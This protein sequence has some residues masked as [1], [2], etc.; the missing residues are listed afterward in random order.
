MSDSW[1]RECGLT[2]NS[3]HTAGPEVQVA[4]VCVCALCSVRQP[5]PALCH[6]KATGTRVP[7]KLFNLQ[8]VLSRSLCGPK[9]P[10]RAWCGPY[11]VECFSKG[12]DS[13]RAA[14]S[15]RNQQRAP[16]RGC[17]MAAGSAPS[18]SSRMRCVR[19]Q[20][21][22]WSG[23]RVPIGYCSALHL[24]HRGLQSFP[25]WNRIC[26]FLLVGPHLARAALNMLCSQGFLFSASLVRRQ[27]EVLGTEFRLSCLGARTFLH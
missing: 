13:S 3:A 19:D 5:S 24:A 17:T 15:S 9:C 1:S 6:Q 26:L 10:Q 23:D 22:V 11:N 20:A 7:A 2:W 16:V 8:V 18:W 14:A 21:S 4:L 27:Q 25:A 12:T